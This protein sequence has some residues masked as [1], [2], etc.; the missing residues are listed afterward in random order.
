VQNGL[1]LVA[2]NMRPFFESL[3]ITN[4]P[5]LHASLIDFHHDTSLMSILEDDY[6]FSTFKAC[7]HFCLG[8]KARPWLVVRPCIC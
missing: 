4:A 7:I 5:C 2:N 6:I 8:K 3:A 1:L